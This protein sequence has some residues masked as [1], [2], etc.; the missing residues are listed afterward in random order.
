MGW[1]MASHK[2]KVRGGS[3]DLKGLAEEYHEWALEFYGMVDA[4][5]I[6][7]CFQVHY[8]QKDKDYRKKVDQAVQYWKNN[9]EPVKNITMPMQRRRR[10][11][12]K[13]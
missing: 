11:Q 4:R 7:L 6:Q 3:A 9:Y 8:T 5:K 13:T 12:R 1:K 10:S 2:R